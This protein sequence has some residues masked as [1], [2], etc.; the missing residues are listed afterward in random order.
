M[1]GKLKIELEDKIRYNRRARSVLSF[2][3]A[4]LVNTNV[5][6]PQE[7]ARTI[8]KLCKAARLAVGIEQQTAIENEIKV[9][10]KRLNKKNIDW[11]EFEPTA[12][13]RLIESAAVLKPYLGEKEKGVVYLSFEYQWTRLLQNCDIKEF[14]S[15]Y[16]LVLAPVWAAPYSLVN[17]LLPEL[18][19][20]EVVFTHLSDPN[21]AAILP[22][23]SSKYVIVPLLCSNW[24]NPNW[25]KPLPFEKKDIDLVMLANFGKYKRH[26]VLFKALREMPQN[27]RIVLIGQRNGN[28]TRDVLL[29]EAKL[30]GVEN[31][32]ELME[33]P[34]DTAVFDA[35]ARSKVSVILSMREGSCVAVTESLFADTPVALFKDAE[36]GSRIFI[37][38]KTGVFLEHNNVG[39]QLTEFINSADRYTPRQWAME[40]KIHC[41]ESSSILNRVIRDYCKKIG[42][43]WSLDIAAFHWRPFPAP[44]FEDD[45]KRLQ[46]ERRRIKEKFGIVIGKEPL[47]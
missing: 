19:E 30:Y 13:K 23:I 35:L 37:N 34:A 28:R 22:R 20:D 18:W 29:N 9:L 39:T 10:I 12:E 21:D 2:I 17:F 1:F 25:F 14:A 41:F 3:N 40:N 36:V 8:E 32:F 11:R 24:V 44:I 15:Q 42:E 45:R 27:L 47:E 38:N 43:E 7:I 5:W 46:Q 4:A 26:F 16:R 31:R 33:S 6:S